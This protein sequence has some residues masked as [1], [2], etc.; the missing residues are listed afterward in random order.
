MASFNSY[1]QSAGGGGAY[2]MPLYRS[3][4]IYPAAGIPLYRNITAV[5]NIVYY[6]PFVPRADVNV[7]SIAFARA[8]GTGSV[9]VGLYDADSSTGSPDTL[10]QAA[11]EHTTDAAAT[12]E[13]SIT[14]TALTANELYWIALSTD[15]NSLV[16]ASE[17][18]VDQ[19]SGLY[20]V[21][22]YVTEPIVA[23]I[24]LEP[25]AG[26]FS[27]FPASGWLTASRTHAALPASADLTSKA[28]AL[29]I[30]FLGLVV[31]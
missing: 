6:A 16:H 4:R 29:I 10:L 11:A 15:T 2:G 30:P 5:Q 9:R 3:G 27:G 31:A 12:V 20:S 14:S 25:S 26:A 18:D 21:P 17:I 24:G 28:Q 22:T 13:A 1:F 19:F 23:Q 7:D 8:S